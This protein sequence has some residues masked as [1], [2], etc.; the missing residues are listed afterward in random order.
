MNLTPNQLLGVQT[1]GRPT[2]LCAGAGA[3]KTKVIVEKIRCILEAGVE[4]EAIA[5]VTFTKKAA[6]EMR[7]RLFA[8]VGLDAYRCNISNWHSFAL[9]HILRPAQKNGHDFFKRQKYTDE[10]IIIDKSEAMSLLREA[11]KES[12]TKDDHGSWTDGGG[13]KSLNKVMSKGRA[14]GRSVKMH[15]T[16]QIG[17][18]EKDKQDLDTIRQFNFNIKIWVEYERKLRSVNAVDFDNILVLAVHLLKQ[19]SVLVSKLRNTFKFI[20]ADEHQDC[21]PV[22]GMLLKLIAGDGHCLTLVGDEKQSIYKFR[23]ADVYQLLNAYKEYENMAVINMADNFRSTTPIINLANN[24]ARFMTEKITDGQM[25]P[26]RTDRGIKPQ[27]RLFQSHR[28]EALYVANAIQTQI[29]NGK[30]ANEIAVLYRSKVVKE[31]LESTLIERNMAVQVVG[32]QDFFDKKEVK[33]WV[34]FLRFCANTNDVMAASRALDAMDIGSKGITLRRNVLDS[35]ISVLD[36]M[37]SQSVKGGEKSHAKREGFRSLVELSDAFYDVFT[38]IGSRHDLATNLGLS[39]ADT[40]VEE[41]WRKHL[42]RIYG[43]LIG[44]WKEL[45]RPACEKQ[46]KKKLESNTS[47][48]DSK[49]TIDSIVSK[50]LKNIELLTQRFFDFLDKQGH[51]LDAIK[52]I[53]MLLDSGETNVDAVQF[54]TEHASKGLEFKVVYVIGCEDESHFRGDEDESLSWHEELRL[55]Y[56][57]A[58]RAED[59]LYISSASSRW[60]YNDTKIKTPLRFISMLSPDNIDVFTYNHKPLDAAAT[61]PCKVKVNEQVNRQNSER[62]AGF[63]I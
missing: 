41:E 49:E 33:D 22:Q 36:Y 50:K 51:M 38:Q 24:I 9:N 40:S 56:V 57:A 44:T 59:E 8:M 25:V 17:A 1:Q 53:V 37:R 21:N 14:H 28:D 13:L 20:L 3:G 31:E 42:N 58:T 12:L 19:D 47:A 11:A 15:Y 16:W 27:Y 61:L 5:A 62:V 35:N 43:A 7:D 6:A 2:L 29:S 46:A 60:E 26:F 34:A 4:P 63:K 55:F 52:E 45:F 48:V 32:E 10:I 30:K 39:Y 18:W 23:E 54:M